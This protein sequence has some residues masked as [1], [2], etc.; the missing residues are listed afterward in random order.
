[1][2]SPHPPKGVRA[3]NE[4]AV[5]SVSVYERQISD[6]SQA[7]WVQGTEE[8]NTRKGA[9][10]SQLWYLCR[11]FKHAAVIAKN[12]KRKVVSPPLPP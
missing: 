8:K 12:K 2:D 7:E 3:L 11:R 10:A 1:M 5:S 4:K 6:Q 9:G